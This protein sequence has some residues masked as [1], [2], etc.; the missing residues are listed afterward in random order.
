MTTQHYDII[1]IG[2]GPMGLAAAYYAAN[3]QRRVLVLERFAFFNGHGASGGESRQFRIQYNE[4]E[5]AQLVLDSLPL[6]ADLQAHTAEELLHT[7]GCLWFGNPHV[8]GAEGQI[9]TVLNVM[10]ELN[11][12]YQRVQQ[13]DL[14]TRYGFKHLP[15]AYSGFFQPDGAA[16]NYPAT[17]R[18][19]YQQAQ[20]SGL[21]TLMEHQAV[22]AI[23]PCAD[24]VTVSTPSATYHG[25]KLIMAAGPYANDVLGLLGI[26]IRIAIWEMVSAYFKRT[27]PTVNYPT[28]ISFDEAQG[29]DP[30]LYYGFPALDWAK[31]AEYVKVAANYPSRIYQ[32]LTDYQR[33]P[34]PTVVANISHWVE[35]FMPGLDPEPLMPSTCICAIV[36]DKT[37]PYAL[38]REMI[39]D[40]APRCLP[41]HENIIVYATGWAAKI[42]PLVGKICVDLA[43]HGSTPHDIAKLQFTE[44]L[45]L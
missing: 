10:E 18:V 14:V 36:P 1:I 13:P 34:D 9:A 27:D 39:L 23:E 12:D 6:W 5:I 19:L 3:A 35:R 28:W 38:Q 21:V 40:F 43:V 42:V 15:P 44:D 2:G 45:L 30:M 25:Q 29:D 20:A 7:A 32:N 41:H 37:N 24:G 26:P 8:T 16:I 17:L 31:S 11:L 22:V 4:K 33:I